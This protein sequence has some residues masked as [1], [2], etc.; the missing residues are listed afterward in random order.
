MGE[1]HKAIAG[2]VLNDRI[3]SANLFCRLFQ[4]MCFAQE[5]RILK[6]EYVRTSYHLITCQTS[7]LLYF[8]IKHGR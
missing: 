2:G 4:L 6:S 1:L 7:S 3:R 8:H 5:L